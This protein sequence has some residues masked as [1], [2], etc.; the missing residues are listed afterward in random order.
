MSASA[1]EMT[2]ETIKDDPAWNDISC[3]DAASLIEDSP[4]KELISCKEAASENA[5]EPV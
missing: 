5:D 3:K 4:V 2:S 1:R